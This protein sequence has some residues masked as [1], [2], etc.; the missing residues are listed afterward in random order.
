[1][2]ESEDIKK[3][4]DKTTFYNDVGV[5]YEF[6]FLLDDVWKKDNVFGLFARRITRM[7]ALE[8]KVPIESIGFGKWGARLFTD[9]AESA[10]QALEWIDKIESHPIFKALLV[11]GAFATDRKE[12]VEADEELFDRINVLDYRRS[13]EGE[14]TYKTL[15]FSSKGMLQEAKKELTKKEFERLKVAINR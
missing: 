7:I 13:C 6:S 10:K 11:V 14:M 3:L 1:M 2:G 5:C 9:D 12:G 15:D 8:L 4:R